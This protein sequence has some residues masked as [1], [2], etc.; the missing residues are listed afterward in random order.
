MG[1][2]EGSLNL[3]IPEESFKG[4]RFNQRDLPGIAE[5]NESL[6]DFKHKGHFGWHFSILIEAKDIDENMLPTQEEKE[7]LYDFEDKI[8]SM[9]RKNN[10]VIFFGNVTHD[11][12]YELM[13]RVHDPEPVNDV[14]QHLIKPGNHQR[15][16]D[17]RIDPDEEWDKTEWYIR[18]ITP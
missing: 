3:N 11:G 2:N 1:S 6:V 18:A 17:Y 14:M 5:I 15:Y 9:I 12:N 4:I 10:N 8:D 13:Y 16:F 7:V